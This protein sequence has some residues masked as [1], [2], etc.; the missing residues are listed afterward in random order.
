MMRLMS[1]LDETRI[2]RSDIK[3]DITWLTQRI[4]RP[5][6][7]KVTTFDPRTAPLTAPENIGRCPEN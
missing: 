1:D 6:P 3:I 7:E 5:N 2:L 4:V